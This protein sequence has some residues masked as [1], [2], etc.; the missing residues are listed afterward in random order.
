MSTKGKG[1]PEGKKSVAI[2][3]DLA[4]ARKDI[5]RCGDRSRREPRSSPRSRKKPARRCEDGLCREM[6]TFSAKPLQYVL[7]G[8]STEETAPWLLWHL[9]HT[10]PECRSLCIGPRRRTRSTDCETIQAPDAYNQCLAAFGPVA[11]AHGGVA[12]VEEPVRRR[13]D[14]R[15][16]VG[17]GKVSKCGSAQT[18]GGHVHTRRSIKAP[19]RADIA[20]GSPRTG[21]RKAA[22]D[23]NS[24]S[25][26]NTR[27]C[28]DDKKAP[29]FERGSLLQILA[30]KFARNP[31][32]TEYLERLDP[33]NQA[34]W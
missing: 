17:A 31:W 14:G 23:C 13:G 22:K 10:Q 18:L 34:F 32:T 3:R 21:I 1:V 33:R 26:R 11:H 12:N 9:R 25:C 24:A 29:A 28:V 2:S 27:A 20:I 16:S 7:R 19:A 8:R 30:K 15:Q 4:A 5:D 6:K